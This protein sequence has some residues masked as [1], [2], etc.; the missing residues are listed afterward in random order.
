MNNKITPVGPL[1]LALRLRG[2]G[3]R[4]VVLV[5]ALACSALLVGVGLLLT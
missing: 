3:R 4:T 1:A 5:A 2:A